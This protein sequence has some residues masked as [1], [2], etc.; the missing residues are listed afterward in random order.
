MVLPVA[1]RPFVAPARRIIHVVHRELCVIDNLLEACE[2]DEMKNRENWPT[3]ES[4]IDA[5]EDGTIMC[6]QKSD[7]VEDA[8]DAPVLCTRK[9]VHFASQSS[10]HDLPASSQLVNSPVLQS[11][12]D[13]EPEILPNTRRETDGD[14]VNQ[15]RKD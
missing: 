2:E 14:S 12:V 13:A 1:L 15:G 5:D 9:A 3:H 4:E 10:S 8:D 6:T 11:Q 7:D